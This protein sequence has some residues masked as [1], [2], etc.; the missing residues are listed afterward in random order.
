M[1][2]PVWSIVTTAKEAGGVIGRARLRALL[3]KSPLDEQLTAFSH[4]GYHFSKEKG[5]GLR[6]DASPRRLF[7]EEIAADLGTE[8]VGRRVEIHWSVPSTN[9]FA[10]AEARRGREGTAIFCEEQTAG[11]GRFGRVWLAPKYS[12]LLFSI[13]LCSPTPAVEAQGL[14]LGGAVAVAEAVGETIGLP[15]A[16]RWPN[17]V[18]VEGRKVS[19][20]L[21]EGVT[22]KGARWLL[23]GIGVNVNAVGD[24]PRE[25]RKS[26]AFL[27]E[28]TEG[29][30]DRALLARHILRRLDFWWEVLKAGHGERLTSKWRSLSAILGDFVTVESGGK[31]HKGRVVDLDAH[32]GLVLQMSGGGTRVFAPADATLVS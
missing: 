16:I 3:G 31:R 1:T 17:D 2:K 7:A 19:G 25:L 12:S 9:D 26:A 22:V 8:T 20:V 23:T 5:G 6:L 10:R 29:P 18:L 21:V 30:V 24:L 28:F 32:F 13:A 14:M 27:S 4:R 11:R 15:A